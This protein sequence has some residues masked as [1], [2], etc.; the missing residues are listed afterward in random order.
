MEYNLHEHQ[1]QMLRELVQITQQNPGAEFAIL[2]STNAIKMGQHTVRG[3]VS[4]LEALAAEGLVTMNK[5]G[6]GD[7]DAYVG[8]VKK[9]AIDAVDSNFQRPGVTTQVPIQ[10]FYAPVGVV[11]TGQGNVTI[12]T[13]KV[14]LDGAEIGRLMKQMQGA[15]SKVRVEQRTEVK[16]LLEELDAEMKSAQPKQS[17]IK[18]YLLGI[19]NG[20]S[21]VAEFGANL[22]AIAG[23]YGIAKGIFA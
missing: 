23:A 18:S 22:A 6:V 2:G 7:F 12:Q 19:W 14:G 11:H 3:T 20:T 10:N 5:R 1:R 17:R 21:D 8:S 15:L 9:S 4:D 13:Q 16:E